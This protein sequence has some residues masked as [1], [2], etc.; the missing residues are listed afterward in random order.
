MKACR[1]MKKTM[2][3][4]ALLSVPTLALYAQPY[5]ID[6]HK[7]AGGGGGSSNVQYLVTGTLGQHDAGGPMTGG[8]FSLTGGFWSLFAVVQTP[9]APT[10]RIFL[11][12]TN[13]VVVAWP[14][15]SSGFKLQCNADLNT[16]NWTDVGQVPTVVG[17][18]NQ[19]IVS[20]VTE[21]RFYRLRWP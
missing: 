19:T 3:S 1:I 6:W 4:L 14:A 17:G 13:A 16:T 12:T 8:R 15:A 20:P 7:I 2:L 5:S 10:L 11:T 18:E 9:G 21:N